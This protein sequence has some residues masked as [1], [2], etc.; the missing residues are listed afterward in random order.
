MKK[1]QET[2]ELRFPKDKILRTKELEDD[3]TIL[4][5]LLMDDEEYTVAEAQAI[6]AEY[7][8]RKVN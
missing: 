7:R 4:S 5:A 3:H 8:T 1:K 6:A 2:E